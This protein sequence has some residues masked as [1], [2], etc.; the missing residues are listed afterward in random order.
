MPKM[1]IMLFLLL[2]MPCEREVVGLIPGHDRPKSSKL[3]VE[4][5]PLGV[6]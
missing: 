3:V 2:E 1:F 5:S 4:A 6:Q